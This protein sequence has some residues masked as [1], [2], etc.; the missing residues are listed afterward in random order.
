MKKI[1]ILL[2]IALP[3]LLFAGGPYIS[4][5]IVPQFVEGSSPT[6]NNRVPFWFWGDIGGLT[7]MAT[8]HYYCAL[9]TLAPSATSNGA[10]LP[11][12]VNPT[13]GVIRRILNPSMTANTGYDS[14]VADPN[15]HIRGWFGVEPT[16]N[17]RFTPG[18]IL[19]PKVMLNDGF[20]GT[21]VAWRMDF[22]PYQLTVLNFGTTSMSPTQGSALWDSLVATPKNFICVYDN[23]TAT[24]RPVAIAIVEHDGLM[25]KQYPS[26]ATFYRNRVDSLNYHWGTI[27]PNN[28]ANGVR[29]L[30]ERTFIGANPVDTVTDADGFWCFGT[31]TVNM[32]NGNVGLFLN[33]TFVLTGSA[34][35]PDTA[36]TG[37]SEIFTASSNSPNSTYTWDFGDAGTGTGMIANHTYL[38]PGVVNAQVVISTGGCSITINQTVVVMLS[39]G[40]ITPMPLSFQLMPNPTSGEIFVATKDNHEKLIIVTDLLGQTISSQLLTGNKVSVDLSGQTPGVYLISVTDKLT[41]KTGVKK[42]VLQ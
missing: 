23:V 13:S 21:V 38:T 12:V 37:V 36:W 34:V 41:G 9:D 16:G 14:L 6:N 33:S 20:G 40:I 22:S 39:T 30:E 19:C 3:G 15:G 35:I 42:I 1:I 31:N 8:Y 26:T 18:R 24:G 32:V 27:I 29:A 5:A 17:P 11:Y 25:I 7:P 10:G 2:A 4:N 28:L